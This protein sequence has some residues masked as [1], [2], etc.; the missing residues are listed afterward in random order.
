MH[1]HR[2]GGA[3][4]QRTTQ[5]TQ[6]AWQWAGQDG[7]AAAAGWAVW[8]VPRVGAGG[9]ERGVIGWLDRHNV[10]RVGDGPCRGE[11]Q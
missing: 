9:G 4:A 10:V 7:Q 6:T 3:R 1:H 2:A 8:A 11:L 5:R